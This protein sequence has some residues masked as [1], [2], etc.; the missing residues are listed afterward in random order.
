MP[1][2]SFNTASWNTLTHLA[3]D[4]YSFLYCGRMCWI[5]DSREFVSG[6]CMSSRKVISTT[7][8]LRIRLPIHPPSVR[9]NMAFRPPPLALFFSPVFKL[10][11]SVLPYYTSASNC[12]EFYIKQKVISSEICIQKYTK[13]YIMQKEFTQD[14]KQLQQLMFS[15]SEFYFPLKWLSPND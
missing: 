13:N 1:K 12:L 3:E 9:V 11:T 10:A 4:I 6:L 7:G 5:T 15:F 2:Q 14:K 8:W